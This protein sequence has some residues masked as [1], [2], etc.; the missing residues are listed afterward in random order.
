MSASSIS[1]RSINTYWNVKGIDLDVFKLAN[2]KGDKLNLR[3]LVIAI[4]PS[5]LGAT[6]IQYISTHKWAS[7]KNHFILSS[8]YF[9]R[10][11]DIHVRET[12]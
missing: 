3:A 4:A 9:C 10:R 7:G 2:H 11:C 6:R 12:C 1:R 8:Y 5:S